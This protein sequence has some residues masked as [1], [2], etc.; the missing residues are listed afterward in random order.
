[1]SLMGLQ[2]YIHKMHTVATDAAAKSLVCTMF[3]DQPSL[4]YLIQGDVQMD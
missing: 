2:T 4:R 3:D 1:M